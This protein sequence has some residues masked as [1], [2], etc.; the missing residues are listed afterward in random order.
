MEVATSSA[1]SSTAAVAGG[2]LDADMD[3]SS[4]PTLVYLPRW[5]QQ[6]Q[7]GHS[8]KTSSFDRYAESNKSFALSG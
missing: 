6:K 2:F 4:T 1:L 8:K 3:S 5:K 7:I